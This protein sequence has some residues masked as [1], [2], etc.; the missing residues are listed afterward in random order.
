MKTKYDILQNDAIPWLCGKRGILSSIDHKDSLKDLKAYYTPKVVSQPGW[1]NK[2]EI[3][4]WI[5][6]EVYESNNIRATIAFN[7]MAAIVN[8]Y[9]A[10]ISGKTAQPTNATNEPECQFNQI[11]VFA[12]CFYW[13]SKVDTGARFQAISLLQSLIKDYEDHMNLTKDNSFPIEFLHHNIESVLPVFAAHFIELSYAIIADLIGIELR[14]FKDDKIGCSLLE[15]SSHFLKNI[16]LARL[17]VYTDGENSSDNQSH[18]SVDQTPGQTSSWIRSETLYILNDLIYIT[19]KAANKQQL[20]DKI[21]K[22]WRSLASEGEDENKRTAER[23]IIANKNVGVT[24]D[25]LACVLRTRQISEITESTCQAVMTCLY[26]VNPEACIL[27]LKNLINYRHEF[28]GKLQDVKRDTQ[29]N[30]EN[31]VSSCGILGYD[32]YL[33]KNRRTSE[34]GHI[35]SPYVMRQDYGNGNGNG[36]LDHRRNH[37]HHASTAPGGIRPSTSNQFGSDGN[38]QLDL[39]RNFIKRTT[40]HRMISSAASM[41][42]VTNI[43]THTPSINVTTGDG[44]HHMQT[45]P[46][47]MKKGAAG[48]MSLANSN[49]NHSNQVYSNFGPTGN[50]K[51]DHYGF[52]RS[53]F[54]EGRISNADLELER[55]VLDFRSDFL[56]R[57]WTAPFDISGDFLR[58]GRL[59]S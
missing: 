4:S 58:L 21:K 34:N 42:D 53:L 50:H 24:L 57:P 31:L 18:L 28:P 5:Q 45:L 51:D 40:T 30:N 49:K 52:T 22:C 59:N 41:E 9:L 44:V 8:D 38:N 7:S 25:F 26:E 36:L 1:Q 11:N 6:N 55:C 19:G 47:D 16:E 23:K 20:T 3:I 39:G 46:T 10:I 37:P 35:M 15:I 48:R 54:M 12:A 33:E 29:N 32:I 2:D 43:N 56:P 27:W 13:L 17:V 14:M